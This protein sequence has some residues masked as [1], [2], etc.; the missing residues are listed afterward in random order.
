MIPPEGF[1]A[2]D[3]EGSLRD[4]ELESRRLG[5]ANR[6]S[7]V[8][9]PRAIALAGRIAIC[10]VSLPAVAIRL[11]TGYCRTGCEGFLKPSEG[12]T[13]PNL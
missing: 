1:C 12:V 13:S 3:A 9:R 5:Q 10:D 7:A 8:T 6:G 11:S 4:G 2:V